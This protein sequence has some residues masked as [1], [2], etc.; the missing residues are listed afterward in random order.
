MTPLPKA[1]CPERARNVLFMTTPRLWSLWPFLPLMRRRPGAAEEC[2][3]L[4]DALHRSGAAGFSAA[5]IECN[6]FQLPPT[7]EELL[8]LPRGVYDRPEEI[9]AAGWR[10][11]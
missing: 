6:L 11:D 9:I 5:V 3:L 10:V 4:Y 8:A 7:E 2:G 1:T